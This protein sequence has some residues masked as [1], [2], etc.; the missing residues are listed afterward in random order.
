MQAII[1][2][3]RF[4]ALLKQIPQISKEELVWEHSGMRTNS[5]SNFGQIDPEGYLKMISYM[6]QLVDSMTNTDAKKLKERIKY[7]RS[8]I[9]HRLQKHGVDTTNWSNVNNFM[10]QPRIAGKELYKMS[11]D[12]MQ[13]LIPKLESIL[14]K[15]KVIQEQNN[16]L[17]CLN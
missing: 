15:D 11:I 7:L 17:A 14:K 10:K 13:E 4:F 2:H 3:A 16:R 1:S 6:Q 8:A 5:L 12:E 9:L